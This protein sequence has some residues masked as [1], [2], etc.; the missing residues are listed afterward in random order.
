MTQR[1]PETRR[2]LSSLREP[3]S[4]RRTLGRLADLA[5]DAARAHPAGPAVYERTE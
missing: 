4:R 5:R 2:V 1:L 3:A